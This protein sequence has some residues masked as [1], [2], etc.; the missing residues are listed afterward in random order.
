MTF[1]VSRDEGLFE[2]SGTSLGSIFA[3]WSNLF[4]LRMWRMIFDII[5]FNQY[6]LDLLANEDESEVD[7]SGVSGVTEKSK[8]PQDVESI[9]H[10]LQREGYSDSF[11]DDYLIPMAAAVWSTSP[12]KTS[13]NFPAITLI[14]FLWNHHLLSTLATRPAWMTIP[15]GSQQYIDAVL[16]DFPKDSIHLNSRVI[17]VEDINGKVI[18]QFEEEEEL[19][20]HVVLACHGDQAM[21]IIKD[22]GT[23]EERS[24]LSGFKTS[25][26]VAYLHSDLSVSHDLSSYE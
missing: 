12:D 11:R 16:K 13:L 18:L 20:D 9:G 21:E 4:S 25:Q 8:K 14:R 10:Y 26:N 19:F 23:E 7:V 1:G 24:I 2:W 22:S 3:Q 5:R 17:G 6:A 15:G